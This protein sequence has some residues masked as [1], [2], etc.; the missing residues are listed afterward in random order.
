MIPVFSSTAIIVSKFSYFE[1][2]I[3]HPDILFLIKKLLFASKFIMDRFFFVCIVAFLGV[4]VA[5][6]GLDTKPEEWIG[7]PGGIEIH[8]SCIHRHEGDFSVKSLGNGSTH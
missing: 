8:K 1:I 4:A 2:R 7:M 6:A 3:Q 5:T